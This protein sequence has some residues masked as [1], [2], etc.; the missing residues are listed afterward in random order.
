MCAKETPSLR[1]VEIT[2][3]NGTT[4]Q[5]VCSD[6]S[7]T[8]SGTSNHQHPNGGSL[9]C[10]VSSTQNKSSRTKHLRVQRSIYLAGE[11]TDTAVCG[12][13][14]PL[15]HT[16]PFRAI[17]QSGNAIWFARLPEFYHHAV[18]PLMYRYE[19]WVNSTTIPQQPSKITSFP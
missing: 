13:A 12:N 6:C 9:F 1:C 16:T 2:S 11:C 7:G 19:M 10:W 4:Q 18:V 8:A 14:T 15:E 5:P 3:R 17:G